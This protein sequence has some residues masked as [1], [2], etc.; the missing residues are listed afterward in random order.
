[1]EGAQHCLNV[2][3]TTITP[4][5]LDLEVVFAKSTASS[6]YASAIC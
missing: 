4:V 6:A 5:E 3:N 2:G 1:M